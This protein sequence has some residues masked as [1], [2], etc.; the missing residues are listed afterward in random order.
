MNFCFQR[1]MPMGWI[2]IFQIQIEIPHG[3]VDQS[4]EC[5]GRVS[6]T[7]VI[8]PSWVGN[9][10]QVPG[11]VLTDCSMMRGH[12]WDIKSSLIIEIN[13]LPSV[14]QGLPAVPAGYVGSHFRAVMAF[15]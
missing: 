10:L 9:F 1:S 12:I 2:D 6:E 11:S 15:Q 4:K 13:F 8:C 5:K 3:I 7:H 14:W